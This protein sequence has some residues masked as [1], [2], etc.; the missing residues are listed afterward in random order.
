MLQSA[1]D[2][3]VFFGMNQGTEKGGDILN[4]ESDET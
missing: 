4:L 1:S 3:D 2:I